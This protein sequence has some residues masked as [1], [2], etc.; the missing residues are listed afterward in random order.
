MEDLIKKYR[1]T[2]SDFAFSYGVTSP[3]IIDIVSS[4]MMTRDGV[5]YPGGGFVQSVVSNDLYGAM[6]RADS[7]CY[8]NLKVIVSSNQ[9]AHVTES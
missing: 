9:F 5:G 1:E 3:H 2:A 6:C 7:E 8:A 4:V